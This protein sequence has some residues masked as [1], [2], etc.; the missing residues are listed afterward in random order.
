MSAGTSPDPNRGI[1]TVPKEREMDHPNPPV[2]D[3]KRDHDPRQRGSG[4]DGM[5]GR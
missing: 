2:N 5:E 4:R 1:K 3:A